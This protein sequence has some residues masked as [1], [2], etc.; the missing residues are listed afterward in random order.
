MPRNKFLA[1]SAVNLMGRKKHDNAR[2]I[3]SPT[4]RTY[5]VARQE[6]GCLMFERVDHNNIDSRLTLII[7]I[8]SILFT[9]VR[10]MHETERNFTV[11]D[12]FRET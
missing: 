10:S 2:E 8:L 12:E 5:G 3:P 6:R 4:R 1:H 9:G 11:F 7:T